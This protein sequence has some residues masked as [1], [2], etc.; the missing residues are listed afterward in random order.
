MKWPRC[1]QLQASA[2]PG[3]GVN[4]VQI[5]IAVSELRQRLGLTPEELPDEPTSA[6]VQAAL[7]RG[8]TRGFAM[9]EGMVLVDE[10]TWNTVQAEGVVHET[11]ERDTLVDEA[12]KGGDRR[13]R[14]EHRA[15]PGSR[16]HWRAVTDRGWWLSGAL[17]A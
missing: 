1:R 11:Q 9:P 5:D 14:R 15:G 7:S 8:P 13:P 10:E 3:G 12:S 16:P 17:A 6:Q 2:A 4:R